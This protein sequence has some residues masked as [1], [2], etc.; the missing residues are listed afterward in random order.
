MMSNTQETSARDT[1]MDVLRSAA[2]LYIVAFN[3]LSNYVHGTWTIGSHAVTL[4]T[5]CALGTFCFI[6][7]CLLSRR[8]VL[9]SWRDVGVFYIR[10]VLRIYPLYVIAL[11]AFLA[12]GFVTRPVFHKSLFLTNALTAPGKD[13][14]ITLWFV[15]MI[16]LYYAMV[17][18]Y[19]VFFKHWRALAITVGIWA[20]LILVRQAFGRIDGRFLIQFPVFAAGIIVGRSPKILQIMAKPLGAAVSLAVF[21]AAEWIFWHIPVEGIAYLLLMDMAVLSAIPVLLFLGWG[22]AFVVKGRFLHVLS[23]SS[24]ALYLFHRILFDFGTKAYLRLW[25]ERSIPSMSYLLCFVL[26]ASIAISYAIQWLYDKGIDRIRLKTQPC[27]G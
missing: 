8:Y 23:Y 21:A 16:V 26:P 4:A 22:V 10:R 7:G 24:F 9:A 6:S 17:P 25:P 5:A 18:L 15:S 14:L 12:L 19:L 11:T 3:H 1:S 2:I 20:I 27:R 13:P